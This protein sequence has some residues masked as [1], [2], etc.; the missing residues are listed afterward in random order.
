MR[1]YA[2]DSESARARILA[3]ALLADGSLDKSEIDWLDRECLA[4]RLGISAGGLERTI[5][6]F[7]EDLD[8]Y[9]LRGE[10]GLPDLG[11]ATIDRMFDEIA[12]PQLRA[13][14]LRAIIEV[15]VADRRIS[16]GEAAFASQAMLRWQIS[17]EA[18]GFELHPF[19]PRWPRAFD[20][21]SMGA[22]L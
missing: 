15:A 21:A 9:G 18:V 10:S 16:G 19:S 2:I 3:A 14:L 6:Q 4:S 17:P 11:R 13:H 5:Q 8:Q 7:C 1:K 12:D 20:R 22:S